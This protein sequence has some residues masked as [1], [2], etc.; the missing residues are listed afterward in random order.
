MLVIFL[1][2][3]HLF[4][5]NMNN[6]FCFVNLKGTMYLAAKQEIGLHIW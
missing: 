1:F 4:R 2:S 5:Q 6:Y 3:E